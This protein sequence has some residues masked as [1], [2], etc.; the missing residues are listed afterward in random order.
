MRK[1]ELRLDY[2]AGMPA[3][4]RTVNQFQACRR[5]APATH[6]ILSEPYAER[7]KTGKPVAGEP[8]STMRS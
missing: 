7:R 1:L 5:S 4:R 2:P 3:E 6:F 8:T